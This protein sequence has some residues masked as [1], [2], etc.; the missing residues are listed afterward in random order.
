MP[1]SITL[2]V[3][4]VIAPDAVAAA[5]FKSGYQATITNPDGTTSANPETQVQ[6]VKK[7]IKAL[8]LNDIQDWKASQAVTAVTAPDGNQIT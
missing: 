1:V 7:R 4:D 6:S 8:V 5:R 3:S 2:T